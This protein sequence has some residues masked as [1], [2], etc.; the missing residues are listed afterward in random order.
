MALLSQVSNCCYCPFSILSLFLFNFLI[1][2]FVGSVQYYYGLT[3]LSAV[4]AVRIQLFFF[5][6]LDK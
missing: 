3:V 2:H 4:C 5:C 1:I 6:F